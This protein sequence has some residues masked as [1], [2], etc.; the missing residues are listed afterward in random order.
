LLTAVLWWTSQ[1]QSG[2]FALGWIAL[3]PFFVSLRGLDARARWRHG[4]RAGWLCYALLNWWIWPTVTRA[5]P[6]IGLPN[7]AGFF[8]GLLAVTLIALIHGSF[9][10][11]VALAW[12]SDWPLFKRAP[13]ILPIWVAAVWAALDALRCETQL[14]HGWGALAYTQWRDTALLQ[15]ASVVGQ[16]G[17]TALCVWFAASLALWLQIGAQHGSAML[18]RAPIGVWVLLH[19]IGAWRLQQTP[20]AQ[21]PEDSL[22]VLLVQ[23]NVVSLHKNSG[24][25]ESAL[26][27]AIRLTRAGMKNASQNSDGRFDLIVW[28]ETTVA[29]GRLPSE[30]IRPSADGH[31]EFRVPA[32]GRADTFAGSL[33]MAMALRLAREWKTPLLFGANGTAQNASGGADLV[34]A[35]VLLE[36]D[37]RVQ[38]QAKM[39]LVPF[40]ERASYNE[41]LPFLRRLA[42]DPELAPAT[43]SRP[44]ILHRASGDVPLATII[45]FESGF[46]FPARGGVRN[47]ARA[48]FVLTNDEWFNGTDAPW[49]HA[50]MLAVRAAENGVATA[51]SA[52]GG[53][54]AAVDPQGRFMIKGMG[55]AIGTGDV[56]LPLAP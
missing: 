44:L 27:Q 10:S 31:P 46:P 38:F 37:G 49:E 43:Q 36:P 34:N 41:W 40:G 19:L 54:S 32:E 23:T 52:N 35:A 5:A 51:Q 28:P 17:L 18:W 8:L 7:I 20:L 13:W 26:D 25:G 55:G 1:L 56:R 16:H 29:A 12:N 47:G 33:Q 42:P 3:L 39:R 2:L 50:A 6:A 24:E 30:S 9:V 15:S 14:A 45:C 53:L 4:W 11:L 48:L 21:S 22:R